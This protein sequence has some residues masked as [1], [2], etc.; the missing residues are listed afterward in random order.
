[1]TVIEFEPARQG[2]L[3]RVANRFTIW[4][5]RWFPDAYIFALTALAIAILASFAI[6]GKPTDIINAFGD[7]YWN[8]IRFTY[9]MAMVLLTGYALATSKIVLKGMNLLSAIPKTGPQ[10]IV[11]IVFISILGNLI[12][13]GFG[14]VLSSLLVISLSNRTELK[15]DYRAAAAAAM[16]GISTIAMLGLSSGPA[17][18]QANPASMPKELLAAGGVI[19]TTETLFTWQNGVVIIVVGLTAML[20]AYF[21]SPRGDAVRTRSELNVTV[22]PIGKEEPQSKEISR[23][24][25]FLST[26]PWMAFFIGGLSLTWL[27]LKIST[28]GLVA[29]LSDLNNYIF[30]CLTLAVLLHGN[31]K[32]FLGAVQSAVP[33]VGP[34][35]VQFPIYAA[36]AAIITTVHNAD[37]YSVA[38]YLGDF[39]V[40]IGGSYAL[41]LVVGIYSIIMGFFVPAAGA[42]WVL[43]APYVFH[44]AQATET[45]LGWILVVFNGSEALTNFINPFWMLATLGIVSLKPRNIVGYTFVYFLVV[46]PVML[47]LLWAFTFTTTYHPPVLPN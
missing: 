38:S 35:L 7:G 28:I 31:I 21:T 37:G 36:T 4:A 13:W 3:Q 6:G 1:M 34:I 39:F 29:T 16:V 44:A 20:A 5:E 32:N 26:S 45:S 17:L 40:N 41:P 2:V 22:N 43:E 10:A 19:P 33:S 42:R 12:N 9:Q 24:G 25:D 15:M 8:L 11:F 23:P 47:G 27:C 14:T 18:L 30:I 46:T